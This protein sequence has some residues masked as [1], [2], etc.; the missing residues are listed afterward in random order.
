MHSTDVMLQLLSFSK[1]DLGQLE[2]QKLSIFTQCRNVMGGNIPITSE[3]YCIG[4]RIIG[5]RDP[6]KW[7]QKSVPGFEQNHMPP[8]ISASHQVR[9][10]NQVC[11][12]IHFASNNFSL[13]PMPPITSCCNL[14]RIM[15]PH[16]FIWY[17]PC[18]S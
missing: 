1:S 6:F 13:H 5:D 7:Y 12:H 15:I 11:N 4:V 3:L 14:P 9:D 16:R 8:T 10:P 17:N 18:T 2:K